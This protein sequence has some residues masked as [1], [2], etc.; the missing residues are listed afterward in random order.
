MSDQEASTPAPSTAVVVR[1][2]LVKV[3][4]A[5]S[6]FDK[7]EA[8]LAE[9][10]GK[11]SG[12]VFDVKTTAGMKEAS[13]ARSEIREPRYNVEKVRKEAKAPILQLGRDIEARASY[14]TEEL[15]KIEEP[16]HAQ[17]K[18]EE[19]R[20]EEEAA[21]RREAEQERIRK[22]QAGIN[23]IKQYAIDATGKPAETIAVAMDLL[24]KHEIGAWAGEFQ[25]MARDA[26]VHTM[27]KLN[28]MHAEEVER[29]AAAKAEAD[30]LAAEQARIK[31]EREE[32]ERQKAAQA[33]RDRV[34]REDM[35]RRQ[36]EQDERERA[37]R[38]R[39]E[40]ARIQ[41]EGIERA[42]RERR[43]R[44]EREARERIE[45][46]QKAA[47]ERIAE[48]ERIA[49]EQREEQDRLA[50]EARQREEA[51]AARVREEQER[52][53]KAEAD[54]LEKER[55][56]KEEREREAQEKKDAK[57]KKKREREEAA[58]RERVRKEQEKMDAL[59]MLASFKARFG[60]LTEFA[61]VVKAIDK[62]CTKPAD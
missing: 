39:V 42:A 19:K 9:L 49:R 60:H 2:N 28:A 5:L 57:E 26:K 21:A 22:I 31:A 43:E 20:K 8:G 45:A 3:E 32:L 55:L 15:L 16:I 53:I 4:S 10:R 51:E 54:R 27:N 48:Q 62:C 13:Q 33:E 29:E 38:E 30:R 1:A 17:I 40:A 47:Q 14:I 25:D 6:E 61:E 41:Q 7:V 58:E 46:E 50:R 44:E 36:R 23:E 52:R 59:E 12:V 11:F 35:E 18:A 37:E 24:E 56:A 34:A